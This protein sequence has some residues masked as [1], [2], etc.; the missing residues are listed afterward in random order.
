MQAPLFSTLVL[1]LTKRSVVLRIQAKSGLCISPCRIKHPFLPMMSRSIWR[2]ET[3]WRSMN[4]CLRATNCSRRL[5]Q[6]PHSIRP[7]SPFLWCS[8]IL[9]HYSVLITTIRYHAHVGERFIS[10]GQIL[11]WQHGVQQHTPERS[12]SIHSTIMLRWQHFQWSNCKW[13]QWSW[14]FETS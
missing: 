7:A 13:L 9:L 5:S 14:S 2:Q 11:F 12:P 3:C 6:Y 8:D 10:E 1:E 4:W